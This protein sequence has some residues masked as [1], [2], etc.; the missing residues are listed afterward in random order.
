VSAAAAAEGEGQ[1]EGGSDGGEGGSGRLGLVE[2]NGLDEL[3][4]R[5]EVEAMEDGGDASGEDAESEGEEA[6]L[7]GKLKPCMFCFFISSFIFLK[8]STTPEHAFLTQSSLFVDDC[9]SE[10]GTEEELLTGGDSARVEAI[11]ASSE[12]SEDMLLAVYQC[13]K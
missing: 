3:D 11:A 9:G 10:D 5:V 8:A 7:G 13:Y 6:D 12:V 2:E 4:S 1:E